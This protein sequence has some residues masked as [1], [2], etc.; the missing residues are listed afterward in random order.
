MRCKDRIISQNI[1]KKIYNLREKKNGA[2]STSLLLVKIRGSLANCIEL[3]SNSFAA[4]QAGPGLSASP[5]LESAGIPH[6]VGQ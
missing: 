3:G 6:Q 5:T 2:N 4:A 1:R